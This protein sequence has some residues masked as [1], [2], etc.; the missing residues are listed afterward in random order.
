[1]HFSALSRAEGRSKIRGGTSS[2]VKGIICPLIKIGLTDVLGSV[3][4]AVIQTNVRLTF[5]DDLRS[6]GLLYFTTLYSRINVYT[7]L[8]PAKFVS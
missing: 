4:G 2:N 6:G 7:R 3:A 5:E 1:M 8:F